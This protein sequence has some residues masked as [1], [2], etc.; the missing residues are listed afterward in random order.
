MSMI[1]PVSSLPPPCGCKRTDLAQAI[2]RGDL[3]E[4]E[5][6]LKNEP[7]LINILDEKGDAPL[8]TAISALNKEMVKLLVQNKANVHARNAEG[9]TPLEMII[10]KDDEGVTGFEIIEFLI[11]NGA[12]A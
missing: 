8:H 3:L 1:P 9:M 12:Y 10:S 2:E 4:V 6:L 7:G 11:T 5:N